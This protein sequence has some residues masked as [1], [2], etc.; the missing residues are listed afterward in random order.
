M[1][2]GILIIS[3]FL[4]SVLV[5]S[6][7]AQALTRE[8]V[9]DM[10]NSCESTGQFV[11]PPQGPGA[12]DISGWSGDFICENY[13]YGKDSCLVGFQGLSLPDTEYYHSDGIGFIDCSEIIPLSPEADSH[14]IEGMEF[15][16]QYRCCSP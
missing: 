15:R 12:T 9:L 3:L 13:A 2:R 4:V 14:W 7:C 1:K 5:I 6:G 11:Y 10:L 16:V 8:D